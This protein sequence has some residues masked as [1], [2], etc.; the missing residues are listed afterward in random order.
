MRN[1]KIVI[2]ALLLGIP[3]LAVAAGAKDVPGSANWYFYVDL[4]QMRSGGPGAAVYDWLRVEVLAEIREDIGIDVEKELDRVTSYATNEDQAVLV[5]E[6]NISQETQDIVMAFIASGGDIDPVKSSGK[7]YY[8]F[9]GDDGIDEDLTYEAGNVGFK[10]DSLGDESWISMD[11]K[12]K[13]IIT[14]TE[15]HM[16]KMLATKGRIGSGRNAGGA[17]MVLTA[18]KALVQ[19]GMKSG[20]LDEDDWDSNI[21]RNSEEV[22]FLIAAA[23]D[24]LAIEAKLLTTEPE[25]AE[26]LA[27]VARGLISLV[28][29]DD[30]MDVETAAVL[31]GT[32]VESKGN[33]LSISLAIDPEI[34]VTTLSD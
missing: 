6:G 17:L 26:S 11:V 20:V 12:N 23:K 19:A 5:L 33:E 9:G 25:M 29:F 21:L 3:G 27:S 2:I 34:V 15:A 7:T 8:H 31:R 30:S 14:A 10:I 32:K 4:K 18:E 22:A 16:Q 24:K 28:S 1:M 13:I